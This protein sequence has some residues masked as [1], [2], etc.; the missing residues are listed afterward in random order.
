MPSWREIP[1]VRI[2]AVFMIGILLSF[3]IDAYHP[4]LTVF[5]LFL[6]IIMFWA[7]WQKARFKYRWLFG[8]AGSFFMLLL[9]YQIAFFHN[10]LHDKKYLGNKLP[11]GNSI[12]FGSIND[13]PVIKGNWVRVVVKTNAIG[14]HIDSIADCTGNILAY[15]ARDSISEKIAYG[16]VIYLNAEPE[17]IHPPD[18]PHAFDYQRYLHFQNIHQ[19]TFVRQGNWKILG[20]GYGNIFLR[21]AIILQ[22]YFRIILKKHL[23]G[24]KELAVGAALILGYRDEI[25]EEVQT[26]YSQTGAMHVL[27]VS[28]LHVGIIFLLLNF[29]LKKIKINTLTF[30]I[31]KVLIILMAIWAFA[32]VT[33]A[34]PSVIRAAVMFSFLN[35]GLAF[36][37]YSSIY[38]TLAASAFFMLLF[39]P[40]LI[41][42]VGFQL[43]YLAVFGIVFF[44]PKIAA[45]WKINNWLG[46]YAWQLTCV[47]FAAQIM[48]IP[49]T[50]YYFNQLPIYFWLTGLILVPLAGL[51]LATGIF[52]LLFEIIFPP[53]AFWI[54]KLLDFFLWFGNTCV[55]HIQQLPAS[56]IEGIWIGGTMA[57][58]LYLFIISFIFA[59]ASKNYRWVIT[60]LCALFFI[61]LNF[62][63]SKIKNQS[64]QQMVIYKIYKHSAID[65]FDGKKLYTVTDV[66]TDKKSLGFATENHRYAMGVKKQKHFYFSDTTELIF[67]HLYFNKNLIQFYNKKI[68]V[69]D[70]KINISETKKIKVDYTLIKNSPEFTIDELISSI[71]FK[72][73]IFDNSNKKWQV[74]KW[75]RQCNKLNIEYHDITTEGAF[76]LNI[77]ST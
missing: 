57:L 53:L 49:L 61:S 40:F 52:L 11:P 25:P 45:L 76:I 72:K 8:A 58:L 36:Q 22:N 62:A 31:L 18:N 38:N 16:D 5:T 29:F 37:R 56:V 66:N 60:S 20:K 24:E 1:F 26:A 17:K 68:M 12:I 14:P 33:G 59:V 69:I 77:S 32:L 67:N 28:G 21:E 50:F 51:E 3:I 54:G 42:S 30:R 48:T 15:I 73:V 43:S 47:S 39:N 6:T 74:E 46:N 19:Q 27:A 9:G 10:E 75:K 64:N 2:L 35:V 44:Q 65:F 13:A 70:E 41:A 55:F 23:R 71:H 63:F 4:V 7:I 34:A